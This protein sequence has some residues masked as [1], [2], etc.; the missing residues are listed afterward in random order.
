M[1]ERRPRDEN[2][3]EPKIIRRES[4]KRRNGDSRP[5]S[6]RGEHGRVM[7]FNARSNRGDAECRTIQGVV[8]DGGEW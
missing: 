5:R 3:Q 2:R 8:C 1:R 4:E 6:V 7:R